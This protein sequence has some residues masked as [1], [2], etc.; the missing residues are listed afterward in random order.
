VTYATF[1]LIAYCTEISA[2]YW[3]LSFTTSD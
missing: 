1:R 2:K 3:R